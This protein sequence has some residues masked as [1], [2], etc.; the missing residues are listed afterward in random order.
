MIDIEKAIWKTTEIIWAT[1]KSRK[2]HKWYLSYDTFP[3]VFMPFMS[4]MWCDVRKS[5]HKCQRGCQRVPKN[6][7]H[8][9]RNKWG[10]KQQQSISC[11]CFKLTNI[12]MTWRRWTQGNIT[13]TAL[14]IDLNIRNLYLTFGRQFIGDVLWPEFICQ[15]SR[16]SVHYPRKNCCEIVMSQ[17][18]VCQIHHHINRVFFVLFLYSGFSMYKF[19][20]NIIAN[21]V[22]AID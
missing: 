12:F 16:P 14:L 22:H 13:I 1:V 2:E 11:Y 6:D 19:C 9:T 5:M 4:W 18:V 20:Y 21:Q 7:S 10:E 17:C 3:D 8:N 15:T